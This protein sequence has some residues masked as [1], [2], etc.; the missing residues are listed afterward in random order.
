MVED[1]G[2]IADTNTTRRLNKRLLLRHQYIPVHQAH[3]GWN[4]ESGHGNDYA[5]NSAT[6]YDDHGYH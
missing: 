6:Q 2:H 3:E 5:N 1:D 4:E